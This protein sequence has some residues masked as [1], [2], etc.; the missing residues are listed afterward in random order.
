[1]YP[2]IF[3]VRMIYSAIARRFIAE[4]VKNVAAL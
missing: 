3:A 2:Q 1:M 4:E